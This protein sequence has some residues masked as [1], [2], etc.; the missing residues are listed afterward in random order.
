M[1]RRIEI[2]LSDELVQW[3][4]DHQYYPDLETSVVYVLEQTKRSMEYDHLT[5]QMEKEFP[6][7]EM[8]EGAKR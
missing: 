7:S 2:E 8:T 1:S 3:L 5:L 4:E 6:P